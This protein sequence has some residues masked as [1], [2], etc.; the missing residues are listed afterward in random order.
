MTLMLK[1]N[2]VI[3][4]HYFI[5]GSY[6][7]CNRLNICTEWHILALDSLI[8]KYICIEIL[9]FMLLKAAH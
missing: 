1:Y 6:Y 8:K 5:F 3:I 2:R 4:N 7:F 9:I